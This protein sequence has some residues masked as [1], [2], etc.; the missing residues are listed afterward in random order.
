MAIQ[1][2]EK[3]LKMR[4]GSLPGSG[5]RAQDFSLRQEEQK[6]IAERNLGTPI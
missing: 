5:K 3:R 2:D 6:K 4:K 1:L